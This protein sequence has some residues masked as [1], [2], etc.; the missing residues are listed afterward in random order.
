MAT[1]YGLALSLMWTR[2]SPLAR[3]CFCV[4]CAVDPRSLRPPL[5]YTEGFAAAATQPLTLAPIGRISSVYKERFGTPRQ[6]TVTANVVGGEA[7]DGAVVLTI[8]DAARM[9]QDL[10]G[11][12]HLWIIAHLHLNNGW[13]PLVQ[14]P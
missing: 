7:S 8:D 5:E 1:L 14:P 12:S 10:D 13:K 11:F 3:R 6:P 2:L 4:L 9:L